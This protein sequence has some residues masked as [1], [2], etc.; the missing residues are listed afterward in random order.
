MMKK[1]NVLVIS[2]GPIGWCVITVYYAVV[3]IY[4]KIIR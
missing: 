1:E 3:L 2:T 4:N